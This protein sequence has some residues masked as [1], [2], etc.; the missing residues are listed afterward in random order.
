MGMDFVLTLNEDGSATMSMMDGPSDGSWSFDGSKGILSFND[1]PAEFTVEDG[2][3]I[4]SNEDN[5][6][7][8]TRD[9]AAAV[10]LAP[11][12]ADAELEDFNGEWKGTYYMAVGIPMPLSMMGAVVNVTIEDGTVSLAAEVPSTESTD[13]E[14]GDGESRTVSVESEFTAELQEDG[15][16]FVDFEGEDVLGGIGLNGSGAILTLH[17]DGKISCTTPEII[18][19][20]KTLKEASAES[21]NTEAEEAESAEAEPE[22]ESEGTEGEG[23]SASDSSES[24]METCLIL[25]LAE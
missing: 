12:V 21:E 22:G 16:L 6:M 3:L 7:T 25:E 2:A 1:S 17:E 14:E 23:A 11:A 5:S 8:F 19:G 10:S 15:T 13:E 9:A 24:S 20:M 4:I 18:E